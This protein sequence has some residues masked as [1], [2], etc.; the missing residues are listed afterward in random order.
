MTVAMDDITTTH[1][2]VC[3]WYAAV[4]VLV[5]C[6]RPSTQMLCPGCWAVMSTTG[7]RHGERWRLRLAAAGGVKPGAG[8]QS[9]RW[10]GVVS[11][12][13]RQ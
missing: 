3:L 5:P 13:K 6:R 1:V 7:R 9:H 10:G 4:P 8:K 12:Y 2:V 11:V